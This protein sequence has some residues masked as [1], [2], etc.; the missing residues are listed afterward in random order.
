MGQP[1]R[2]AGAPLFSGGDFRKMALESAIIST[3]ALGAYGYGIGRYGQGPRAGS[4]A[5][6]ALVFGQLLHAFSCRS[7]H[8]SLLAKKRPATNSCLNAAVG[9]S[10]A[11]QLLT[12]L[13]PGLRGFLGLTPPTVIDA[14]VIGASALLPF[15]ANESR[16]LFQSN[17]TD[18]V[19]R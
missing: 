1:P 17:P 8:H 2:P 5:F 14:A 19:T 13:V 4:L 11:L 6:Q 18:E 10:L 3:G 16:K 9:G 7:E 12:M 15:A